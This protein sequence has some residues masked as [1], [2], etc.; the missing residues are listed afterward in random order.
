MRIKGF[1][2]LPME[3]GVCE[4]RAVERRSVRRGCSRR[5]INKAVSM[6]NASFASIVS[7]SPAVMC[8]AD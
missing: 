4:A 8:V 3:K 6:S 1:E 5:D 2:G 7:N